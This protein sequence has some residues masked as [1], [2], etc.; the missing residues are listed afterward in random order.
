MPP[1]PLTALL[2]T[3][4]PELSTRTR[5]ILSTLGCYN[6]DVPP[7]GDVAALVGMRSRFQLAR[8]LREEGLPPFEE[9]AGWARVLYWLLEA[10]ATSASLRAL[11]RQARLD[12]AT[13]YRLVHR[14]TR[15][16]WSEL[17]RLGLAAALRRFRERCRALGRQVLNSG[18]RP[19]PRR[20]SV[21]KAGCR[22]A[23]N[24]VFPLPDGL[25]ARS[26]F[27]YPRTG[28]PRGVL[29]SKLPVGGRPFDVA[30]SSAGIAS[31][32]RA[33]AAAVDFLA[34]EPLRSLGSVQTGPVPTRIVF[35]RAGD[36]AYV[37]NQ[38]A[39]EIGIIDVRQ[40]SQ[41]AAVTVPG[42]P[43]AALLSLDGRSL[44]VTTNLDRLWSVSLPTGRIGSSIPVSQICTELALDSSGR[45]LYV[46]TWRAGSILEVDTRTLQV[47]RR[48]EVGG[49]VQGLALPS[50][51]STL[52]AA[53][54]G[55]W[56]DVIHLQT[57][58]R[59]TRLDFGSTAFGVAVSPD[60]AVAYVSLLHTGLV[61]IVDRATLGIRTS[62][63][64]GGQPRR[65]T[66]DPSGRL[67]LIA[68]EQGWVDLVV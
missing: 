34:L 9:L 3:S 15:L 29:A 67:A 35:N 62:L 52:F 38:F 21:A 11:A 31:V 2:Q 63:H 48:F 64:T 39:E 1:L 20:S 45:R 49:K 26:S 42:H 16:R 24:L 65:I 61:V 23:R 60:D 28:H 53:N 37:T 30:I 50:D 55:G 57:G 8:T 32:T 25:G 13:A 19:R 10:E 59:L 5:A 47:L 51:G 68:N 27:C 56:L 18:G 66:F 46:P 36:L 14:V 41:V 7:A 33:H 54:E 12:A 17:Q 6:G 58:R 40:L 4:L 22:E 44:Y 43:M